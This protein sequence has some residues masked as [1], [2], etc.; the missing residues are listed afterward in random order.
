MFLGEAIDFQVSSASAR[1]CRAQHPS[2]RTPVGKPIYVRIDPEKCVA[3][4]ATGDWARP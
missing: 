2:L 1:C 4:K 3:L